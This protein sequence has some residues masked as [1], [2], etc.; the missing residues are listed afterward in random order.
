MGASHPGVYLPVSKSQPPQQTGSKEFLAEDTVVRKRESA[1]A[2]FPDSSAL[3]SEGIFKSVSTGTWK[4]A[5]A[6]HPTR[7]LL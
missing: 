2:S 6:A 7:P 3:P 4:E 5:R 1:L